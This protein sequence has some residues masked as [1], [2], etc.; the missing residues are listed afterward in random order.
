MNRTTDWNGFLQQL[1]RLCDTFESIPSELRVEEYFRALADIDLRDVEGG[2]DR[3]MKAWTTWGKLPP[4]GVVRKHS[5]DAWEARRIEAQ[6]V[7][8][9]RLRLEEVLT[10]SERG[11]AFFAHFRGKCGALCEVCTFSRKHPAA[12]LHLRPGLGTGDVDWSIPV[13]ECCAP[14]HQEEPRAPVAAGPAPRPVPTPVPHAVPKGGGGD[15]LTR[16]QEEQ[17]E[18]DW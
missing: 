12:R 14:A 13:E 10:R 18:R 6:K 1:G 3:T 2:V 16:H 9:Q 8:G 15:W 17:E 11:R 5:L 4:P 7:Q